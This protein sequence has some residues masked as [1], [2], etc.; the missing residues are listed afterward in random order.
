VAVQRFDGREA[1]V[2]GAASGIGRATVVRLL[3]EG[4]SVVAVDVRPGEQA[5]DRVHEVVGDISDPAVSAAAVD[6]AVERF[7]GLH[8][9]ANVAGI[10]RTARTHEHDLDTW[11]QV[12]AVNLTG[13]FLACKA[14]LPVML[15]GGGGAIVNTAS[16]AALSGHPWAA[17]YSASKG[18]VLAF[19]KV[20]AVEYGRDGIRANCV[21]PG[22]IDTPITG[23]FVFPEGVDTRLITRCMALDKPRGPETVAAAVAFLASDDA[24][25]VN[26]ESL[27]VDGGTL[28]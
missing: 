20:L 8:V 26:G 13:T 18:G 2:T 16:T 23:D 7:G 25:H 22:S 14:A 4:A 15:A 11:H 6:A 28:S 21:C 12:L 9:L 1:I 5:G 27:R 17:A 19:T 3:D 24:A 10:L